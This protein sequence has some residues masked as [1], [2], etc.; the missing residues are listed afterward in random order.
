MGTMSYS[1]TN[2][3]ERSEKQLMA[4]K[5]RPS[6]WYGTKT[7]FAWW[8]LLVLAFIYFSWKRSAPGII[9]PVGILFFEVATL[10]APQY[11]LNRPMLVLYSICLGLVT[12]GAFGF[13]LAREYLTSD[14]YAYNVL[15][16]SELVLQSKLIRA[17]DR[18]VLFFERQSQSL[19][20]LPWADIKAIYSSIAV[21]GEVKKPALSKDEGNFKRQTSS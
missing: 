7:N 9:V 18:G 12:V 16:K 10:L 1:V 19:I 2:S 17:G 8:C 4:N 21:N 3:L 15:L 11:F 13:D 20:L 14:R 5:G 6:P